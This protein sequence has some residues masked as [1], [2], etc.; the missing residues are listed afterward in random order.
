MAELTD[1]KTNTEVRSIGTQDLLWQNC[2]EL[3]I[4]AGPCGGLRVEEIRT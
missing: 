4:E 2:T 3:S 1:E